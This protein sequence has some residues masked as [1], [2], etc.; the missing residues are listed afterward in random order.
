[1][2]RALA[3]GELF[4][5]M[6]GA[7]PPSVVALHGWRRTHSDFS[8]VLGPQAPGGA[9]PSVAPDLPGF[10]ATPD[11]PAAWGSEDYAEVVARL[12]EGIEST[13]GTATGGP[14]V[15][16][17]HSLGGRIAVTLAAR[18]PDL[19]GALVLTGAPIVPRPGPTSRSPARFRLLRTLHRAGLV[20]EHRMQQA[21]RRYGSPDYRASE[22]VMRETL[23]RLVNETYDDA[24]SKLRC[25]VELVWGQRD[26]EA[27]LSVAEGIRERVP[28]A[29]LTV[30]EGGHIGPLEFPAELRAAIVRALK[31]G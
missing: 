5:E 22:G 14:A 8:G 2:L 26:V 18:R 15:V 31:A 10:G 4:G 9:L 29:K 16:L 11:P 20:G 28:Q 27:P 24:L 23:V 30:C 13:D 1:M 6:W 19:V 17:G 7:P 3:G 21:R 12:I 25:P